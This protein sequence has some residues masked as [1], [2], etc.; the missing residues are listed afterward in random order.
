MITGCGRMV[1][2]HQGGRLPKV[3]FMVWCV[4]VLYG[5]VWW[6]TIRGEALGRLP[7]VTYSTRHAT[8][9][10]RFSLNGYGYQRLPGMAKGYLRLICIA[11]VQ[12][13]ISWQRYL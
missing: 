5:I 6:L 3:T 1:A 11:H 2:N 12:I 9:R 4:M 8:L 7:K 13:D 10:S